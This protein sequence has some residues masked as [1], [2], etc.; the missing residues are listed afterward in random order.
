[1]KLAGTYDVTA[2]RDR[3]FLALTDP[4]VLQHCIPGCESLTPSGEHSYKAR[5]KVGIA[6]LKGTYDGTA[7]LENLSPPDSYTLVVEGRG[8]PGFVR[9]RADVQLADEPAAVT[10]ITCAADVHVGG[11]IAS[12]GSRVVDAAARKMMDDFFRA[13]GERVGRPARTFF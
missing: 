6:G 8:A 12:V 4:E 2:T 11:V 7:R 1:M 9:G 10:R 5:L 3:V 13:F